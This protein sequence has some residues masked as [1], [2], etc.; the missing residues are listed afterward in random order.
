MPEEQ[1]VELGPALRFLRKSMFWTQA[2]LGERA[3]MPASLIADYE[4]GRKPLHR[5]KADHLIGLMGLGPEYIDELL[6]LAESARAGARLS[7]DDPLSSRRRRIEAIARQAGRLAAGFARSVLG[8]LSLGGE[9]LHAQDK[10]EYLWRRLKAA[11]PEHRMM[12]VEEHDRYHHWGL[13]ELLVRESIAA[14][15]NHPKEALE[16]AKLGVRVAELVPGTQAWRWRLQGYAGAGLTNAWRVCSDLP[17][18]RKA[19]IR[20][21]KL[22]EDGEA[23][24]PGLLNEA[25]VPWVEAALLRDGREFPEALRKVN[26]ALALD[27]GE[28]KGKILL[29]K[30]NI[31]D[32]LDEPEKSTAAVLEAIPLLDVEQEPRLAW[33]VCHHLVEDLA[34]LGRFEEA[35]LKLPEVRKLAEQLGGEL[36]LGRVVWLA[37]KIDAGLGSAAEARK[38]FEQVRQTFRKPEL[39][40]DFAL[41]SVDL[42]I[43]LLEQ[44]E[45]GR[46]KAIASDMTFIFSSQ[47]VHQEALAAL[48]V[49]YEAAQR[50]AATVNL[51]RRVARFLV[52]AKVDPELR[53][54]EA[55]AEEGPRP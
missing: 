2:Q 54:E 36:D 37:A 4:Q 21:C 13:S 41:V 15:A 14:A 29:T 33:M 32:S 8:L 7:P 19:C 28:L 44:G 46:V 22:W 51:T 31:H 30:A 53:F 43:V 18:A 50:E 25:L 55:G 16:L 11:K 26:E 40:Y 17:A 34:H 42:S 49:F 5:P 3:G 39:S 12:L 9:A 6:G 27:R 10:A 38:G 45:T 35:R 24:D 48:K 20:A 52:R 1:I 47:H 23:G